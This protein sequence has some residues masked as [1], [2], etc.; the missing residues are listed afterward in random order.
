MER[1]ST[2]TGLRD[3]LYLVVL[4]DADW[5]LVLSVWLL[6]SCL[7]G[8][9]HHVLSCRCDS[10][11]PVLSD[12]LTPSCL[13]GVTSHSVLSVR[14]TTSCLVTV[15]RHVL[16]CQCDL[17]RSLLSA[18][19]TTSW[20]VSVT[21][22]V[23]S[24]S[25]STFTLGKRRVVPV[26]DSS[27]LHAGILRGGGRTPVILNRGVRRWWVIGFTLRPVLPLGKE[28]KLTHRIGTWVGPRA[29]VKALEKTKL[30]SA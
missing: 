19:L 29:G 3:W 7:V 12:W 5:R 10:P 15:T 17:P 22:H 21:H 9:T 13:V 27:P 23:L 24:D 6:R 16:S 28:L 4:T 25:V 18:W 1:T 26:N 8:V 2:V 14:L 20:L 30:A 11:R